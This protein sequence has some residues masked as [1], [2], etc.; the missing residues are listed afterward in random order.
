MCLFCIEKPVVQTHS[1][2]NG[3]GRAVSAATYLAVN[4]PPATAKLKAEM[5]MGKMPFSPLVTH[6]PCTDI[7]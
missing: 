7:V 2:V 1:D 5:E 6:A 3:A 4:Q